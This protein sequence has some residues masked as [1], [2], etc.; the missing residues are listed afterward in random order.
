MNK[1]KN[2][3]IVG[4][5][6]ISKESIKRI[7]SAFKETDFDIVCLELDSQR[8]ASLYAKKRKIT[9]PT[10]I[11]IVGVKGYL[12]SL[13]GG[14]IQNKFAKKIGMTP[15]VDMKTASD[16]AKKH[17]S[18]LLL[19]DQPINKTLWKISHKISKKDKK[20]FKFDLF[21]GL[22][23]ALLGKKFFFKIFKKKKFIKKIK[24]RVLVSSG[25]GFNIKSIPND[26]LIKTL[27]EKVKKIYP[28]VYKILVH[29]RNRFMATNL[30]KIH[31]MFPDK[32]I[33]AVVGAGHVSGLLDLL[34]KY[35]SE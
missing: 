31:N 13:I 17:N 15:G 9:S 18:K 33:L 25:A 27:M 29:D 4:T 23:I 5:S 32:K 24:T 30:N 26:E 2:I 21:W 11:K 16:L 14:F 19:I 1:Y 34:K 6:H 12:F 3:E 28:S 10:M 35:D 22:I 7:K 20:N 8:Y